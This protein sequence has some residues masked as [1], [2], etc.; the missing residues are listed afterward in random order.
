[1]YEDKHD[2]FQDTT[3]VTASA[4]T[5][6]LIQL[7]Y[8]DLVIIVPITVGKLFEKNTRQHPCQ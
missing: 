4:Y 1:M 7:Y 5:N 3:S 8:S 2:R 6:I